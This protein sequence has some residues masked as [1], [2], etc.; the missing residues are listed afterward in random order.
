M[1]LMIAA[2]VVL[3]GVVWDRRTSFGLSES[4]DKQAF[5][6]SANGLRGPVML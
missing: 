4:M 1:P 3:E 2:R 5:L 6:A